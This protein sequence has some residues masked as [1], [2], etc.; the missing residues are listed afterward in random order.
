MTLLLVSCAGLW[1]YNAVLGTIA[2]CGMFFVLSP[3]VLALSAL[4]AAFC[5]ALGGAM[6]L[7]FAA[8]GARLCGT[9][10]RVCR[11]RCSIYAR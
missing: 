10:A 9:G 8:M 7:Q 1:G 5:A 2:I 11:D 4:N 3:R 6:K